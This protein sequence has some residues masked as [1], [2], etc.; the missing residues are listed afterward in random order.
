MS[1]KLNEELS[2]MLDDESNEFAARR[3]LVEMNQDDSL[4]KKWNR[5]CLVKDALQKNI[6]TDEWVD[7]SVD[8][9]QA[10][11]KEPS[12]QGFS[13]SETDHNA[14]PAE[15]QNE[16]KQSVAMS[17]KSKPQLGRQP[18][19]I[20]SVAVAA[21]VAFLT[22]ISWQLFIFPSE[23]AG[24]GAPVNNLALN[25][26]SLDADTVNSVAMAQRN[27][28]TAAPLSRIEQNRPPSWLASTNSVSR[29]TNTLFPQ[30]ALSLAPAQYGTTYYVTTSESAA[31][32]SGSALVEQGLGGSNKKVVN[33]QT[34]HRFN[35]Y[36]HSHSEHAAVNGSRGIMPYARVIHYQEI[37]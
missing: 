14:A 21:T 3:L 1:D 2:G 32:A 27:P 6:T 23:P 5:Y 12:Y 22:V 11:D 18:S 34:N 26:P 16:D 30:P 9:A 31:G 28:V 24:I 8:V 29:G 15:N 4:L 10:I 7:I 25:A 17:T 35:R 13:A 37:R 33:A 19:W 20:T 36:F